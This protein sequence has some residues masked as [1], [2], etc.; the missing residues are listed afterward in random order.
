MLAVAPVGQSGAVWAQESASQQ[1]LRLRDRERQ[2]RQLFGP[3][4]PQVKETAKEIELLLLLERTDPCPAPGTLELR[5]Q[6]QKLLQQLGPD[7]PRV[8]AVR[9][10][11]ESCNDS[12]RCQRT[13]MGWD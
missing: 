12:L 2:R 9:V 8:K 3:D 4:H 13:V 11:I 7:H 10:Q 5:L 6:E 1:L